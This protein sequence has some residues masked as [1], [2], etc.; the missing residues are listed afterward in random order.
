M[1][2]LVDWKMFEYAKNGNYNITC[3]P[4]VDKK[5]IL[6]SESNKGNK[7]LG[8]VDI[9][10]TIQRLEG[11]RFP[12]FLDDVESLDDANIKR[13]L[14]MIDSQVIILKVTNDGELKIENIEAVNK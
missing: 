5:S 4:M 6:S 12:V 1:F 7:I 2:S 13:V 14:D 11:V 8:K 10:S 3:I 9:V